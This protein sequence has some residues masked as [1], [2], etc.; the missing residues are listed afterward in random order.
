MVKLEHP[1]T[2]HQV[3]IKYANWKSFFF[4]WIW[5]FW[6]RDWGDGVFYW[7]SAVLTFGIADFV[8][9]FIAEKRLAEHY[10]QKGYKITS[11]EPMRGLETPFAPLIVIAI[12]AILSAVV[13]VALDPVGQINRAQ[14]SEGQTP[15]QEQTS[16]NTEEKSA[17][18][19]EVKSWSGT[20]SKKTETFEI[21]GSQWR[22]KWTN[23]DTSGYGFNLLTILVYKPG[24]ESVMEVITAGGNDVSNIYDLKGTLYLD[25]D[26][27]STRW[28][29]TV[30]DYY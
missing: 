16:G 18:W 7:L 21:K 1:S 28:S 13:F 6:H 29:I 10:Q 17:T 14:D 5:F 27:I 25:I 19:H 8:W 23:E 26:A 24:E 4:G 15:N 30:E 22:I 9:P 20:S 2:K 3:T 12:I 11:Q